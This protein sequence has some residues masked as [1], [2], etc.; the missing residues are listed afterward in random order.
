MWFGNVSVRVWR[1]SF[2]E[3][4]RLAREVLEGQGDSMERGMTY[5]MAL[6][7]GLLLILPLLILPLVMCD[8][9]H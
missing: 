4:L 7:G 2:F 8:H 5:F 1:C 6:T 3:R 9:G